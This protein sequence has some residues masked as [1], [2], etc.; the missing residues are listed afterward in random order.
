METLIASPIYSSEEEI[1]FHA[2]PHAGNL[3]VDEKKHELLIFDWSLTER[4]NRNARKNLL[5]LLS[6]LF[7]KDDQLI[8]QIICDLST[9]PEDT[10]R[11]AEELFNIIEEFLRKLPPINL[12]KLDQLLK[13]LDDI[14]MAGIQFS[15]ELVIFRKVLLTLDGVL[16]DIRGVT[17]LE[18]ILAHYAFKEWIQRAWGNN[19]LELLMKPTTLSPMDSLSL[20]Q[21]AQWFGLRTGF[22]TMSRILSKP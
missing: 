2:D 22:Q 8:F 10:S 20:I 15:S 12:P 5:M 9:D 4:L 18:S 21:S 14:G 13:L 3:Y 17:P 16:K 1:L 19:G 11:K 6:A 7:L